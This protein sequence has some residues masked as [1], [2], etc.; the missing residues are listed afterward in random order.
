MKFLCI[1]ALYLSTATVAV[2]Q[3]CSET[4]EYKLVNLDS[5]DALLKRSKT[6]SS[7]AVEFTDVLNRLGSSGWE[8]SS[9]HRVV[10]YQEIPVPQSDGK[11]P[12]A[13]EWVY[14]LD[15]AVVLLK[16]KRTE[17]TE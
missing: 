2:A 5:A 14:Q 10:E 16:R 17:C 12:I 3:T 13:G 1:F 4:F 8:L 6:K 7:A 15:P 11:E 9:A